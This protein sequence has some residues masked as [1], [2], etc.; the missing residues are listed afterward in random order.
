MRLS[1]IFILLLSAVYGYAQPQPLS[2]EAEKIKKAYEWLLKQPNLPENQLHYLEVFPA[3]KDEYIKIFDPH[4]LD[5]LYFNATAYL[6]KYRELARAYPKQVLPRSMAIG[7]QLV[8]AQDPAETMQQSIVE[9]ANLDPKAFA[10]EMHKLKKKEQLSLI[11]FLADVPDPNN[12]TSYRKL[13]RK[14]EKIEETKIAD[15]LI[16][17]RDARMQQTQ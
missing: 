3:T 14:L 15:M 6:A 8:Y 1:I 5:E 9:M 4:S 17:E 12:Y 11:T 10:A 13:I 16:A 2:P 7:K